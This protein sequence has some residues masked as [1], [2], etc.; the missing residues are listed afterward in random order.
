MDEATFKAHVQRVEP[1]RLVYEHMNSRTWAEA[2]A[3]W[4]CNVDS[5]D[6]RSRRLA[7]LIPLSKQDACAWDTL[8]LIAQRTL[9]DHEQLPK[10]LYDWVADVLEDATKRPRPPVNEKNRPQP[11]RNGNDPSRNRMRDINIELAVGVLDA[12]GVR[13]TR[14]N[15]KAGAT[16]SAAGGSGCD[17]V[18]EAFGMNYKAV[19]KVWTAR[20][21]PTSSLGRP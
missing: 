7:R 5:E 12:D 4:C 10:E 21:K 14:R 18:G 1:I 3:Q 13:P 2:V 15:T 9:R 17:I 8:S 11:S 6:D 16:P 20:E 19:E